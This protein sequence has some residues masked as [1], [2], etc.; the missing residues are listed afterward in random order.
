MSNFVNEE[1][2]KNEIYLEFRD[3]DTMNKNNR[4]NEIE[5]IIYKLRDENALDNNKDKIEEKLEQ[6]I[7]IENIEKLDD[8]YNMLINKYN[9]Y[10][11][12]EEE[13][14]KIKIIY[15]NINELKKQDNDKSIDINAFNEKGKKICKIINSFKDIKID[16]M[17]VLLK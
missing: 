12:L 11:K 16:N 13:H 6:I 2:L 7:N 3:F 5:S 15:Q 4:K 8:E 17:N 9:L 14:K 10:D 1:L